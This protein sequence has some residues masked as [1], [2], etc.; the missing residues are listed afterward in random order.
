[1]IHWT[2]HRCT[3]ISGFIYWLP[4]SNKKEYK[5]VQSQNF[6]PNLNISLDNSFDFVFY[7]HQTM[8]IWL[9]NNNEIMTVLIF[10]A[11]LN[12]CKI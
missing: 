7:D 4:V 6:D 10:I 2:L 5:C 11:R 1:M 12:M 3:D 8:L 9:I